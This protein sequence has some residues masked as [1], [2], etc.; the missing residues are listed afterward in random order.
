MIL[1]RT[2]FGW[3]WLNRESGR[4]VVHEGEFEIEA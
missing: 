3:P 1:V 2:S 4:A